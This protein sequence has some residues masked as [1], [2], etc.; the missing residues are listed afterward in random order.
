MKRFSLDI[1]FENKYLSQVMLKNTI[2]MAGSFLIAKLSKFFMMIVIARTLTP[3]IFGQ[4][5]YIIVLSAFCFCL[6]E[7]GLSLLINREYQQ[8]K[9][10]P[11]QLFSAGLAIKIFLVGIL[12]VVFSEVSVNLIS[13]NNF[14][15]LMIL[16]I[17]PILILS[18]YLTFLRKVKISS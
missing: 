12:F 14:K 15:N 7:I 8:E 18:F 10:E 6:S 4:I 17:L 11:Q 16:I 9:I 13:E 2:W 5:N 1:L 3:E